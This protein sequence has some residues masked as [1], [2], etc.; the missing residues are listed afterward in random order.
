[1]KILLIFLIVTVIC[2]YYLL[3][4]YTLI[5]NKCTLFICLITFII[6]FYDFVF[7][8]ISFVVGTHLLF[9]LKS[10]MEYGFIALL[11]LIFNRVFASDFKFEI[12]NEVIIFMILTGFSILGFVTGIVNGDAVSKIGL[13]WRSYL[14]P[15]F[16]FNGLVWLGF[17]KEFNFKLYNRFLIGLFFLISISTFHQYITFNKELSEL[18]FYGY[19]EKGLDTSLDLSPY[20]YM[21]EGSLRSTGIFVSPLVNSM[22]FSFFSM[23][24]IGNVFFT[25]RIEKRLFY[26]VLLGM[27]LVG[28]YLTNTRIGFI[29][30][31]V[32]VLTS[33]F[34]FI[35]GFKNFW[36]LF[37]M[38][39]MLIVVTFLSLIFGYINDL[40][41]LG[42][43]FQYSEF[44]G[45]FKIIGLGYGNER[46]N[47]YYDSW[48]ISIAL[49]FG[50]FSIFYLGFYLLLI[51]RLHLQPMLKNKQ[52]LKEK[53]NVFYFTTYSFSFSLIYL[54]AFQYSTGGAV[55][56]IFYLL[57]FLV[58][59]QI[60]CKLKRQEQSLVI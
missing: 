41:A 47:V 2:I 3:L 31:F 15:M 57:N 10:W 33:F 51:K 14:L 42:R 21:R 5:K 35:K 37:L 34:Y 49:L 7:I 6:L 53:E 29:L 50:I 48:F 59:N 26:I 23:L 40:S 30:L 28:L 12:N 52:I 22:I 56:L 43:L 46:V 4:G 13:G 55:L 16:L 19:F 1:M 45:Y 32:G 25:L 9:I 58:Y 36:I 18:W 27:S 60:V 24:M 38:P 54:F 17:F 8:N 39:L 44:L 11:I 20:N